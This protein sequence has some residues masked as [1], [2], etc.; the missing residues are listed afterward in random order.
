MFSLK[1]T[2]EEKRNGIKLV[3]LFCDGSFF[4]VTKNPCLS[5]HELRLL[6][7]ENEINPTFFYNPPSSTSVYTSLQVTGSNIFVKKTPCLWKYTNKW[8]SRQ[9]THNFFLFLWVVSW[10]W[11]SLY[12]LL[13]HYDLRTSSIFNI[14]S[15]KK[16][17]TPRQMDRQTDR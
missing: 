8:M 17:Q 12:Q 2:N 16:R 6:L 5:I 10:S 4:L 11:A 1:W 15:V 9:K 14:F 13:P 7:K 3:L